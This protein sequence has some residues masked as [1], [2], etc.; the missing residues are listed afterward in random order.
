MFSLPALCRICHQYHRHPHA[1]C[2]ACTALL[3]PLGPACRSCAIPIPQQN[4][5]ICGACA[6]Q[7]P[8]LDNVITAYR[9]TEPL[10]TLLH[11]FKY[12]AALYLTSFLTHLMLQAKEEHYATECLMPIPLHRQRLH[13]RGF[14]QAAV[15]AQ[16]LST[17]IQIPYVLHQ[18]KKIVPTV[19]QASL[20]AKQRR[21][22]LHQAFQA[23][24]LPYQ[25]VTL[26]DDL[27]TTGA[28]ANEVARTL[29][30]QAGVQRVDLWCCARAC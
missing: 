10:R 8:A 11:A 1:I 5:L 14:N 28:T 26:I 29:K 4:P 24:P 25:H 15:L 13:T 18:C 21:T 2:H 9:F 12:E 30:Q 27:F 6:V 22:N 17:A 19:A 16:H 20:S 7:P 23:A 3:E